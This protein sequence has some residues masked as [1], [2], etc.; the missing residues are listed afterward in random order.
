MIA[1]CLPKM[2]I[3]EFFRRAVKKIRR[4]KILTF[5][6]DLDLCFYSLENTSRA[7]PKSLGRCYKYSPQKSPKKNAQFSKIEHQFSGSILQSVVE[8][9]VIYGLKR[10][11]ALP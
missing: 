2:N 4:R 5:F 11:I 7:S 10:E 3:V 8:N 9:R 1:Y 6:L